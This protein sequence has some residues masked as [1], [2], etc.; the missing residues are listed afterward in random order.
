MAEMTARQYME[1]MPDVF[2]AKNARGVKAIIQFKL[3]G[4]G[5]GDWYAMFKD[6]TCT[7]TEGTTDAAQATLEM[8]ANDYVDL[9]TGKL[10][11]M[12][13][14]MTGKVKASGDISLLRKMQRWFPKR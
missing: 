1:A 11:E 3:S 4:E 13:A 6:G 7:V 5:G 14:F 9:A 8:T 12:K 2:L 10:G